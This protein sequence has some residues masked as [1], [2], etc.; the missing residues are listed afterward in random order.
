MRAPERAENV[1]VRNTFS[2]RFVS[3]A[4]NQREKAKAEIQTAHSKELTVKLSYRE[5]MANAE[6]QTTLRKELIPN[7]GLKEQ[8]PENRPQQS[9][10]YGKILEDALESKV[11]DSTSPKANQE[12]KLEPKIMPDSPRVNTFTVETFRISLAELKGQSISQTKAKYKGKAVNSTI[13]DTV[14][15][16]FSRAIDTSNEMPLQTTLE[17]KSVVENLSFDL[18]MSRSNNAHISSTATNSNSSPSLENL[19]KWIDSHLDLNSRGW[20]TKLSKSILSALS[21]GHQRL[22]FILSPESLGKIN[23]TFVNN[24]SGLDI[25][26]STER[27]A[28]AA[29]IGD[30]EAKLVSSIEVTGQRVSSVSCSSSNSFEQGYNSHQ[31]A[32]SNTNRENSEKRNESQKR[33]AENRFDNNEAT[34]TIGKST[35]DDTIVNI[36]I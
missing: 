35:D 11:L 26:I 24:I 23:V 30:S 25:K 18:T 34:E 6:V 16:S 33:E 31:S 8:K 3:N 27:Q 9:I 14:V 12:I 7:S 28:T 2:N 17:K 5:Q 1:D 4:L 10:S 19:E 21:S 13:T 20:V 29:L 36:T 15:K 32:S 22:T